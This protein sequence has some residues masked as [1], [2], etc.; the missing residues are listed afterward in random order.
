LLW[1]ADGSTNRQLV[2]DTGAEAYLRVHEGD[3][4]AIARSGSTTLN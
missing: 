1:I 3:R 2:F 4:V